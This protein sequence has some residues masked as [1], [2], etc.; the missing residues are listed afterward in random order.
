MDMHFLEQ[1]EGPSRYAG[2]ELNAVHK[3]WSD[4]FRVALSYPDLYEVGMSS[5][6]ILILYHLLNSI[7][8]VVAER[9]FAPFHDLE[10]W[11]RQHQVPL[12][13]LESQKPLES[14]DLIAFSLG[15]ELTYTNV[16][17]MLDLARL[18]IRSDD[19]SDWP[20]IL[21]GGSCAFNPEPMAAFV[22]VVGIGDGE[23]LFPEI[24]RSLAGSRAAGANREIALS[25]L[26]RDVEG[27]YVPSLYRVRPALRNA[28]YVVAEPASS[29]VPRIVRKRVVEDLNDAFA[30]TAPIVPYREPVHDRGVIELFR[31]CVRGC[32]F[33][34]AGISYRPTRERSLATIQKQL[35]QLVSNTGYEEVGLLSLSSTDYSDLPG[36]VDLVR[37]Y[38]EQHNVAISF[39]S[40]RME[41]FPEYLADEIKRTREGSLTFA[42]EA[43]SQ[44]LRDV[45]NKNITEESIFKTLRTV[46]GKGWHLVKFYFMFGLPTETKEDLDAMV[47][48]VNRI[49]TFGR[50]FRRDIGINLSV[51]PFVPRP[52][53]PFQWC[54]QDSL[55]AYEAKIE[56]LR[57][58]FRGFGGKVHVD[59]GDP[60][61]AFLEGLLSRGDRTIGN[62]IETAWRSGAKFDG[63]RESFRFDLWQEA[64]AKQ[65][66]DPAVFL[67]RS[68]PLDSELPWQTIDAGVSID[69]LRKE[70]EAAQKGQLLPT[71]RETGCHACG[72]Q[73][74]LNPCPTQLLVNHTNH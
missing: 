21:A 44:R 53:T 49:Y 42:I 24:V 7:D 54:A 52:D 57:K 66:V 48:L 17:N 65:G 28:P 22:D 50:G 6:G 27:V 40:L 69:F 36:L 38:R 31:G 74:Y 63:W 10:A 55:S 11:L 23:D 46:F 71:C 19:R 13:S 37:A 2:N 72:I 51:N 34:Q 39:P 60:R 61:T 41:N 32:R 20:I 62:V 33:C 29:A 12:F 70:H 14:F 3:N 58:A 30:P 67:H 47:D 1:F 43:G 35:E 73:D 25:T 45:I 4:K 16:L 9:V 68:I 8:S 5:H 64:I 18:P 56:Y 59:F 26:A 15:T